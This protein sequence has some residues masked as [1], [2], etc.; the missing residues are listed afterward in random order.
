MINKKALLFLGVT[1]F[2]GSVFYAKNSEIINDKDIYNNNLE[3]LTP[4]QVLLTNEEFLHHNTTD[5]EKGSILYKSLGRPHLLQLTD[6]EIKEGQAKG[7]LPNTPAFD[8]S[9]KEDKERLEKFST[10]LKKHNHEAICAALI[11]TNLFDLLVDEL[12]IEAVTVFVKCAQQKLPVIDLQDYATQEFIYKTLL[13]LANNE[14]LIA[15]ELVEETQF[16]ASI[17]DKDLLISQGIIYANMNTKQIA[18]LSQEEVRLGQSLGQLPNTQE[19]NNRYKKNHELIDNNFFEDDMNFV[20]DVK[21]LLT[22]NAFNLLDS[23][24]QN[25]AIVA[26]AKAVKNAEVDLKDPSVTQKIKSI[27]K[28]MEIYGVA[29]LKSDILEVSDAVV[30]LQTQIDQQAQAKPKV[31]RPSA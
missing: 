23:T 6:K 14:D 28:T 16:L 7:E 12:Q 29:Y 13:S 10:D 2:A 25:I 17:L 30:Y 9:I 19:F 18:Q 26:L 21:L 3:D 8:A 22:T 27:I 24:Q 31:L 11:E 20:K 4:G 5:H 15:N 1:A